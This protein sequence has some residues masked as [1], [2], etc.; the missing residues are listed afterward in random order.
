MAKNSEKEPKSN[1]SFAQ[2]FS[3]ARMVTNPIGF[4]TDLAK[5]V[6]KR[7][8][9]SLKEALGSGLARGA[10]E[11]LE[12]RPEEIR[13]NVNEAVQNNER[14]EGAGEPRENTG[15]TNRKRKRRNVKNY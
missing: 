7:A 8:P 10:A 6:N 13:R 12:S 14:E 4:G 2:K 9:D 1:R 3:T 11:A 15:N 5:E